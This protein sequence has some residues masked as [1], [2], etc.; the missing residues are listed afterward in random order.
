[1]FGHPPLARLSLLTAFLVSCPLSWA[2]GQ[3]GRAR[4]LEVGTF[5]QVTRYD[6]G[7]ATRLGAGGRLG[8]HFSHI[9]AFE[10]SGDFTQ[11][12]T[13]G[14]GNAV[15]VT[16]L[17]G[18]LL[19]HASMAPWSTVYLGAGYERLYYRGVVR[20]ED[21]GA[22]LLVGD[23]ISL[24]G[25]AAL[26]VEGRAAYFPNS[27]LP[28]N[29]ELFNLSG[30][31]GISIYAFRGA[32]QDDDHDLVENKQDRCPETP[33]GAVVD[34]RGCP[35]DDDGDGVLNGLDS[36]PDT[37][38]GAFVDDGGCPTDADADEVFD[39]IDVCPNTPLGADV[40]SDGCPLDADDDGVFDGL[41]QCPDTPG[42]AAVDASGCP[43][44]SDG[45]GVFDGLDQCPDT[46]P[47]VT[48]DSTGC[49][50]DSDGDGVFDDRDECPNTPQGV[51]V[52][53]RGC[54]IEADGD[55]DGVPDSL[56]RCPNT[57]AGQQVDELGCPVLFVVQEG[58]ARPLVLTG[59]T[60]ETGR[61]ALTQ[62]SYRILNEVAASLLAHPEV[63][64]EIAGHT[65]STGP[66]SLNMRLS[67]ERARSVLTYLAQRGVSPSRMVAQG[68]GP[69]RPIATNETASGR[70][71][72]RRVELHLIEEGNQEPNRR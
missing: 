63:R 6:A 16:R 55:G 12:D 19:A 29:D 60:F 26:R 13:S 70:A 4:Q 64:I 10:A 33:R 2:A 66:R 43:L 39:G 23:R 5:G 52:D 38:A 9:F 40:D 41:D 20:T 68:Y 31:V 21:N 51:E 54:S 69:D 22:H 3:S 11:T 27:S 44:D 34:A 57:S 14:L 61:S 7:L 48:V 58:R 49:P 36:C 65:D 45:D 53:A 59:V 1:M 50:A 56:D 24:G 17:S 42:G 8:Y 25:R 15:N 47:G 28:G 37:P 46:E 35:G 30:S 62:E 72:N 71:Q 32:P 67:R 18:T